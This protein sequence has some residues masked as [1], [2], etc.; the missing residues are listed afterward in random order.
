MEGISSAAL[1]EGLE[2]GCHINKVIGGILENIVNE[3][4]VGGEVTLG[5]VSRAT[6]ALFNENVSRWGSVRPQ[7]LFHCL[8]LRALVV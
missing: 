2:L 1:L 8:H 3:G 4:G 7:N 6:S 5:K